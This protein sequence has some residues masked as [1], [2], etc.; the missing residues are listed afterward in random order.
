MLFLK[1][2]LIAL[3]VLSFFASIV[4]ERKPRQTSQ[5]RMRIT[6][7]LI[8]A[9]FV[10]STLGNIYITWD[11][12][13]DIESIRLQNFFSELK[14]SLK[15]KFVHDLRNLSTIHIRDG[16]GIHYVCPQG[17][18]NRIKVC[19]ELLQLFSAAGYEYL[20]H[21]DGI[22]MGHGDTV[23]ELRYNGG[24]EKFAQDLVAVLDRIIQVRA[25]IVKQ[26]QKQP[27][28]DRRFKPGNFMLCIYGEPLFTPD[29][30][31]LLK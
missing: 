19:N 5:R 2:A 30:R 14:P 15:I 21:F 11:D 23:L 4:I 8:I 17:S 16:Y 3:S 13:K 22:T 12:Q 25:K 6:R 10:L 9:M 29:G 18:V 20:S 26:V 1:Y 28:E 7:Q 24:D 27:G 31:I